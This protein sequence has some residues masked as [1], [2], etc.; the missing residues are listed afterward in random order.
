[1]FRC[2][3]PLIFR[4]RKRRKSS[5]KFFDEISVADKKRRAFKKIKRKNKILH[6]RGH[7]GWKENH[8]RLLSE[9]FNCW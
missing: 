3:L 9:N 5:F 4:G 1:M 8:I 2:F 6:C 7:D